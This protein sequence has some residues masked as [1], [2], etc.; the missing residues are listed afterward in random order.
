MKKF[1]VVILS[2]VLTIGGGVFAFR[3]VKGD[4]VNSSVSNPFI[5]SSSN[6]SK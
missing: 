2:I 5:T 4:F 1:L 3:Y 6:V